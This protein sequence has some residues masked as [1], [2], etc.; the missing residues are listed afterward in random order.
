M[1]EYNNPTPNLAAVTAVTVVV[2]VIVIVPFEYSEVYLLVQSL[3]T[4]TM[5]VMYFYCTHS[6]RSTVRVFEP[7]HPIPPIQPEN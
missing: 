5:V 3:Y 1:D 2:V 7:S 4:S 6:R